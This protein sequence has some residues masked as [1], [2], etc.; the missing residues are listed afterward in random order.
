M[1]YHSQF[2]DRLLADTLRF[3]SLRHHVQTDLESTQPL[4]MCVQG[5]FETDNGFHTVPTLKP[6]AVFSAHSHTQGLGQ[7]SVSL[8][9][10]Y[11]GLRTCGFGLEI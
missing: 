6:L 1:G 9:P 11:V 4:I 2:R 5:D 10:D 3:D 8:R 7:K